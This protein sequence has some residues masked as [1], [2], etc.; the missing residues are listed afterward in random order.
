MI[1]T[2]EHIKN[3]ENLQ[4]YAQFISTN[5]GASV[6]FESDLAETNGKVI[7]VP[8]VNCF[9]DEVV[10][11]IYA[12]ILHEAGHIKYTDFSEDLFKKVKSENMF[13]LF[14]FVEDG[15]IEKRIIKDF[16]GGFQTLLPIYSDKMI[17]NGE[18]ISVASLPKVR[19][20][21]FIIGSYIRQKMTGLG[22]FEDCLS[23]KTASTIKAYIKKINLHKTII[24]KD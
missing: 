7:K 19:D 11:Y 14:N 3:I 4:T 16:T 10:D 24:Y 21:F 18:F 13:T 15:H 8:S 17:K 23:A 1:Y 12:I 20:P 5:F 2:L 9:S 6:V 22:N